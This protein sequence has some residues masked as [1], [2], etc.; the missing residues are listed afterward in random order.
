M[1]KADPSVARSALTSLE[2]WVHLVDDVDAALAAN[3]TVIAVTGLKRFKR[4]LDLHF[5][6][7]QFGVTLLA[8]HI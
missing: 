6:G 5:T 7:P 3:Q 1:S 2:A 8:T 4:V